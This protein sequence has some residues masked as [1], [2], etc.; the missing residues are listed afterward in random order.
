MGE[1]SVRMPR[2]CHTLVHLRDMY[3][4]PR[5]IFACQ[6]TQHKPWGMAAAHGQDE[7]AAR[8][9]GRPGF[10]SDDRCTLSGDRLGTRKN[11]DFHSIL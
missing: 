3:P 7:A 9:D 1:V 4:V 5:D 8:G 2:R 10:R 6:V 11:F